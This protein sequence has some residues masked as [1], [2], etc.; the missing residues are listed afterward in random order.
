MDEPG[1]KLCRVA[2]EY[3]AHYVLNKAL[4]RQ[5]VVDAVQIEER[6]TNNNNDTEAGV[7]MRMRDSIRFILRGNSH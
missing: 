7:G 5:M 4:T 1:D 2:G 6:V 3:W